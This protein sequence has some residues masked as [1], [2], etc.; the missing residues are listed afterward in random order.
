MSGPGQNFKWVVACTHPDYPGVIHDV[1][2]FADGAPDHKVGQGSHM[3][4]GGFRGR[5]GLLND[6][7]PVIRAKFGGTNP[8]NFAQVQSSLRTLYRFLDAYEDRLSRSGVSHQ[9]VHHLHH[10]TAAHLDMM[11]KPGPEGEW[12]AAL[13]HVMRPLRTW[14][15]DA[16]HYH[17]M[18]DLH[19]AALSNR[20]PLRK[21]TSTPEE[22]A[23][24]IRFLRSEVLAIFARWRR[25]DELAAAGRNLIDNPPEE[26]RDQ[27]GVSK[28]TEADAHA[29][30]RALVARSGHPLPTIKMMRTALG[31]P[32]VS[33]LPRWWPRYVDNG[34]LPEGRSAGDLIDLR[35][36]SAGLYPT[37]KDLMLC[38][39]LCLGRSA[40]NTGTLFALD[41]S[42]WSSRYDDRA[43]WVFS[44]KWRASGSYQYTV[45]NERERTSVYSVLTTLIDRNATLRLWLAKNRKA[46][47][48]PDIA[49]RSP[50]LGTNDRINLL[51]FTADPGNTKAVN[52]HLKYAIKKHNASKRT[53]VQV[54]DMSAGDFRDI[55]AEW[56]YRHSRYSTWI[57]MVL[58]GHKHP[59]TTRG[60]LATRAARQEAHAAVK[61]V[62]DDVF[63]QI[64]VNRHWDPVLT[65]AMVEGVEL[66]GEARARLN[67]YRTHRTYDG[68]LCGDPFHPPRQIDPNHPRDGKVRCIQGHRCVASSCPNAYVFKE[69]LPWLVRRVAELEW[70]EQHDGMVKFSTSTDVHDLAQLRKTLSQWPEVDVQQELVLWR[71]RIEDGTHRPLRLAG[72]H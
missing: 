22:A 17:G 47:P 15:L 61:S 45:S 59:S 2:E 44:R 64:S 48:T 35:D 16:V 13:H 55:A 14:I 67:A 63:E 23:S 32:F 1:S 36:I 19:L 28:P 65:R 38:A 50:W 29:T 25:A 5:P 51:L 37:T 54:S 9:P 27:L 46:H 70:L 31:L 4:S 60:Y 69:S 53:K 18:P 3:W 58:L 62:L 40:W 7:L 39:L 42:N 72:Q 11:S 20:R 21:D 52:D 66:S 33:R 49:L 10:L 71:S 26:G 56:V 41:I 43:I 12:A 8:N 34:D 30:Y 24:F 6:L 57:T 68:S